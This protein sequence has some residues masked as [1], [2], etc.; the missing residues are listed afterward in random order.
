MSSRAFEEFYARLLIDQAARHEFMHDPR[1]AARRAGLTDQECTE[2]EGI[3][4]T[5][6]MMAARSFARKR[7]AKNVPQRR[8]AS[9]LL[10][11]IAGRLIP[12]SL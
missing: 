9:S 6:L 2:L 12:R 10:R 1:A 7:A 5:G 3:D 8:T 4:R 11:R